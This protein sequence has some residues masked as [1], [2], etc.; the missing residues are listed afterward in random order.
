MEGFFFFGGLR[1]DATCVRAGLF[2]FSLT[3]NASGVG[4]REEGVDVEAIELSS[5]PVSSSFRFFGRRGSTG[6]ALVDPRPKERP[7]FSSRP[8]MFLRNRLFSLGW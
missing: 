7:A 3:V 2:E 8:S 6:A 5:T 1:I 4:E